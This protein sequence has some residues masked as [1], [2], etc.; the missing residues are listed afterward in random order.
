M[1]IAI[2]KWWTESVNN[3]KLKTVFL[4]KMTFFK[5]IEMIRVFYLSLSQEDQQVSIY[6]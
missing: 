4:H 1:P 5:K 3:E 2:Y 6:V